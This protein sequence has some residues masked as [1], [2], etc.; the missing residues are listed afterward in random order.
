MLPT[1]ARVK[2]NRKTGA[3][4]VSGD[5]EISPV[6]ISYNGL[7]IDTTTPPP[8]GR[9]GNPVITSRS[10]IPI[11]MSNTG[12]ARLQDLVNA[13]E[14]LRVPAK[15]RIAIIDELYSLGKLHAKLLEESN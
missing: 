1:E 2:I 4:V 12:G 7:T 8:V 15:D 14:Q 10:A 3:L 6:V 5:V 13:L 9:P 11:D